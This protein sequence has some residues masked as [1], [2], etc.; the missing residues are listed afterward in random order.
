[1]HWHKNATTCV[2]TWKPI[3]HHRLILALITLCVLWFIFP[4]SQDKV[5]TKQAK[6]RKGVEGKLVMDLRFR[7]LKTVSKKSPISKRFYEGIF[8]LEPTVH[9][10]THCED[11]LKFLLTVL[12][13]V[14]RTFLKPSPSLLRT[15]IHCSVCT[16]V[17]WSVFT[18][19]I[20]SVWTSVTWT[21]CTSIIWPLCI[22]ITC[23]VCTYI[24]WSVCTP[25]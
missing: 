1:M 4:S 23:Q 20:C 2:K 5:N 22:S 7:L 8:F 13:F 25:L 10:V 16:S 21:V 6:D 9:V 24:A 12:Y 17:T 19:T 15:S 3:T 14:C 18:C 11:L